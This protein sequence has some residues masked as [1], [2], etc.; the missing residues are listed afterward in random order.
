LYVEGVEARSVATRRGC[1]EGVM[2]R[3]GRDQKV[4][5]PRPPQPPPA[6]RNQLDG[7]ELSDEDLEVVV[8]GLSP[9]ASLAF[10]NYL[11]IQDRES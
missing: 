7:I 10:A 3:P 11:K 8:G 6:P 2:Q 1:E 4:S 5:P 9:E